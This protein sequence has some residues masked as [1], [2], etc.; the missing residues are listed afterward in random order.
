V[1]HRY[2]FDGYGEKDDGSPWTFNTPGTEGRA[3]PLL[4]GERGEYEVANGRSGLSYLQTMANTANDGFMI[5]EQVW[6]EAQAAPAP[7][8]YQ[9][10][11]ATG[12]ASPLAWAMAQYVRLARA[13]AAGKPVETPAV[14][15]DRYATG[16]TRTVPE[17]AITSPTSGSLA[18]TRTITV[19]GTTDAEK[20]TIGNGDAAVTVTPSGGAFSAPVALQRGRNQITVVVEGADGGTNMRQ[21]AVTSFGTRVGGLTDPTGDDNGPGTYTYPTN[22]AFAKGGFDLTAFDVF[23]DGDDAIFVARIAGEIVNPWGGNEISHQRFNVYLGNGQTATAH[24]LPGTNL[25][26]AGGWDVA[27]VGDGRFDSAGT[28]T[29]GAT[30]PTVRGDMLAV[31]ETHQ[32]AVVVPRAA[33]GGIDLQTAR[34][35]I[36]MFGNGE[37]GEGVGYIRPV[38]DGDYWNNPPAGFGWIKEYRFGGGAGIWDDTPAHDT[39]TRDTN[40][41][42][43]I[44]GCDQTQAQALNWRA[45]S[46]SQLPMLRLDQPA[47]CT[48]TPG[49]VGGTVPP[50]AVAGARCSGL[51]RPVHAG[52]RPQL[53]GHHDR[54]RHLQ[55]RRGDAVGHRSQ[56]HRHR[57][58]RQRLVCAR[59][60]A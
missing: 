21:V 19:T 9:P 31:A 2:T 35:G 46:P 57:P 29:P 6:D 32:I 4:G 22:S 25:D 49:T 16:S 33:L 18:P 10:G 40:A 55:R 14:V 3:W 54:Q 27:V 59:R 30:G 60:A 37:A 48:T 12:S 53:R 44:V 15:S 8:G 7:Y 38:Y 52:H 43:V 47:A 13:I 56:R 45:R 39:D 26:T 23:T 50:H 20:V 42:D 51:L 36:A 58:P 34:Y 17:L 41:I 28:Y 5:P 11:K 24:A 1:W